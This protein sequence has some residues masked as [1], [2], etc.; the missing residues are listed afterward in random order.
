MRN[1]V[2]LREAA[3]WFLYDERIKPE[4]P[5]PTAE[6]LVGAEEDESFVWVEVTVLLGSVPNSPR[7]AER[8]SW[9]VYNKCGEWLTFQ[10]KMIQNGLY[11]NFE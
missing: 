2:N 6:F 7:V 4:S 11:L 5:V 10:I 3:S 8:T 9:A 1:K